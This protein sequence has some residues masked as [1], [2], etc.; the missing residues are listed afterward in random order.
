MNGDDGGGVLVEMEESTRT[1]RHWCLCKQSQSE[2]TEERGRRA[3]DSGSE[4]TRVERK[5]RKEGCGRV[6]FTGHGHTVHCGF[7]CQQL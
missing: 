7:V 4:G 1:G 2:E 6:V 5:S 3:G